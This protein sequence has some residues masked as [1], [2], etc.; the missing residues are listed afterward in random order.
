MVL[1]HAIVMARQRP[2]IWDELAGLGINKPSADAKTG[3][4]AAR[5][6]GW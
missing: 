6:K 4:P 1:S 2:S 3:S 5:P